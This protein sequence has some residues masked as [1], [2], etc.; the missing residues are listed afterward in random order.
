MQINS[1][2]LNSLKTYYM[3][4]QKQ[5]FRIS[6]LIVL[7]LC[8]SFLSYAQK[9]EAYEMNINGVKIIV[10]PSNNEIIEIQTYIKG[11]VQNY[12]ANN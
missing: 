6:N 9:K 1:L 7:L 4:Y 12:M 10:Q 3:Q 8:I 11:G 5:N 2:N